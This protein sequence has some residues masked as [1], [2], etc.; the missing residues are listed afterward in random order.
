MAKAM[1]FY[2]LHD[3]SNMKKELKR[4]CAA[5]NASACDDLKSLKRVRQFN[6]D[7]EKSN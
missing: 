6:L 3:P 7:T 4:A 5:G 2:L 1:G